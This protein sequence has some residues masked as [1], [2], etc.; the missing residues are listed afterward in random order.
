VRIGCSGW[1]YAHWRVAVYPR[2]LPSSRWLEHY[3]TIFDTVEV[4]ATFYRLPK[5]ETVAAWVVETPPGFLFA[6]KA[7]RYLT[8]VKRLTDEGPGIDRLMGAIGPLNETGKLGPML[9]QL[10]ESFA[11]SDDRLAGALQRL[12]AGRHAFEFRHPSWFCPE[13]EEILRAHGAALVIADHPDRPFQARKLTADWTY[14]RFHYGRGGDGRYSETELAEW[15]AL[16]RSWSD[17]T[18]LYAYFNNDWGGYAV[19]NALAF[20]SLLEPEPR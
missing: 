15:A 4:N 8:H 1:S 20:R 19:D 2:G 18:E 9:W 5:R 7:S 12:P 17:E 6:V 16:A 13:V 11:R 3:A 14:F 10:P